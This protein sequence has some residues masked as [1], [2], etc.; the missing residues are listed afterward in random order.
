[1]LSLLDSLHKQSND[2]HNFMTIQS[3]RLDN[4]NKFTSQAFTDYYMSVGINVEH[5]VAHTHTQNGL[6]E[7]LIKRLQLIVRPLLMKTKL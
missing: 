1:M 6:V 4:A 2:E 7:S 5:Y 3:I